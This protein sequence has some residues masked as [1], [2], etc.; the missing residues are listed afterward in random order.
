MNKLIDCEIMILRWHRKK[1]FPGSGLF[2]YYSVILTALLMKV[3]RNR[4]R[5]T[6]KL[7]PV[8]DELIHKQ[9][10]SLCKIPLITSPALINKYLISEVEDFITN[11]YALESIECSKA[12]FY[13]PAFAELMNTIEKLRSYDRSALRLYVM[14]A[15]GNTFGISHLPEVIEWLPRVTKLMENK[16]SNKQA[17]SLAFKVLLKTCKEKMPTECGL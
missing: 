6:K 1:P 17:A 15:G 5:S 12:S 4:R 10:R 11:T 9:V 13:I 14:F 16:L 3:L 8:I 2:N 7:K